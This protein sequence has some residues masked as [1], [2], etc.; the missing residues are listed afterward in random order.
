MKR[1][2]FLLSV[3]LL[4]LNLT[5]GTITGV[6][7]N[8]VNNN[9]VSGA[10]VAALGLNPATGDS[11]FFLTNSLPSG[12][13]ILPIPV[14]GTYKI[15]AQHPDFITS[16]KGPFQIT[17]G[18]NLTV[19][20]TLQP[21]SNTTGNLIAGK[22]NIAGSN[23]PVPGAKV[24][25]M[26]A[27]SAGAGLVT[28]T[29]FAGKYKFLNIVPGTYALTAQK[30]SFVN[31]SHPQPIT[32]TATTIIENLNFAMIPNGA[33]P[34]AS[35]SGGVF[36]V[37]TNP[38]T[39]TAIPGAE[40]TFVSANG[41]VFTA[42]SD[43]NGRYFINNIPPGAYNA[44][45]VK[46]GY[47]PRILNN[48]PVYP[49]TVNVINFF[50][51]PLVNTN[52]VKGQVKNSLT[53]APIEGVFVG[54]APDNMLPVI[55][56]AYTNAEGRYGIYNLPP[57]SYRLTANKPGFN[58]YI[59]NEPIVVTATT[60]INNLDFFLVPSDPSLTATVTG[61]VMT[62]SS[63]GVAVPV[64]GAKVTLF[65]Q[66]SLVYI[67]FSDD[68]GNFT[69][70]DVVTGVYNAICSKDGYIPVTRYPY[71]VVPGIN[72]LQF[73]LQPQGGNTYGTISGV[74]TVDGQNLPVANA[75]IQFFGNGPTTA[76][77]NTRT[78]ANGSY[79]K[80]L[81]P[82]TYFV[83][84]T[85]ASPDSLNFYREYFDNVQT[86][87][88]ATPV[89][90]VSGGNVSN[91]NFGVPGAPVSTF[92]FSVSGVVRKANNM[93]LAGAAVKIISPVSAVPPTPAFSAITN[94]QGE[95]VMNI[96][97]TAPVLQYAFYIMASKEGYEVQF[98]DH[99][100]AL[101]LADLLTVQNGTQLTNIN[102]DL[103]GGGSTGNFTISGNVTNESGA[104]VAGVFVLTSKALSAGML[105]VSLTDSAGNYVTP[106]LP[107]GRY[108][109]LFLKEG[110]I[111]EFYDNAAVWEN[112]TPI[113]ISSG[114]VTG[115]NAALAGVNTLLSF[116]VFA[117]TVKD[118]FGAPIAGAIVN[119]TSGDII[120]NYAI[121]DADGYYSIDGIG[122]VTYD[123][124]ATQVG[125]IS[126]HKSV[127]YNPQNGTMH[128]ID[129][130]LSQSP[131]VDAGDTDGLMPSAYSIAN[132]PNPFNPSTIISYSIPAA[133]L[134]S[135]RVY[136]ALGREVA[137][138]ADEFRPAGSY[139]VQ[140][141]AADLP[142]GVYFCELRAGT[143]RV[144]HKLMLI[145]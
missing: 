83:S 65:G 79:H 141:N 71:N 18:T 39:G 74:V 135:V 63:A 130:T 19:N 112:A 97:I 126:S 119:I 4:T 61:K 88:Q 73:Y 69:I 33:L 125:Y 118:E 96:T 40:I 145:K 12:E 93:P 41:V 21:R 46:E 62:G 9:P 45:C 50:L 140:F 55:Y 42:L 22:V 15:I 111:P 114:N 142:T 24:M 139:S 64:A 17:S 54:L 99:K 57:G 66:D 90:V 120:R 59:R 29:D 36:Q 2:S 133:G 128:I 78:N 26:A 80:E 68:N 72:N 44:K 84:V 143:A 32:V 37:S 51:E 122:A 16:V 52:F 108:Y 56:N 70:Q 34:G 98:Y 11:L 109:N 38:A 47:A 60:Q 106:L 3:L 53:N 31:Y 94:E 8:S 138:L 58:N 10:Q 82:G 103:S 91:I 35:V 116:G 92:T 104:P 89:T 28:Y 48:V 107:A 129:F 101:H 6:V 127:T 43:N 7:S 86:L 134:V 30:D 117:G 131:D 113:N 25:L 67:V 87:S 85:V 76:A 23:L 123:V 81:P 77:Y 14:D 75:L 13:F 20:I 49:D 115:I 124:T 1:I 100:T 136:N 5:A 121:T 144:V 27:N 105:I 102:F 110:Y 137:T 95:Y 132:Y